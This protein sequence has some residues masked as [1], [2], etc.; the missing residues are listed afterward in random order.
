MYKSYTSPI[1]V[2]IV[3]R[4]FISRDYSGRVSVHFVV[5]TQGQ[6]IFVEGDHFGLLFFSSQTNYNIMKGR[7]AVSKD[8]ALELASLMG[9]VRCTVR[10]VCLI[11]LVP[12]AP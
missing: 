11:R 6:F 4:H 10:L 7:F 1:G 8:M 3:L 5:G 2:A 12:F 9:Q